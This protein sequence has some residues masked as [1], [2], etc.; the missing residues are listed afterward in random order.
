MIQ[1]PKGT[2]DILPDEVFK[3]QYIEE[4]VKKIFE[5]P[6]MK[7][8]RV[9]FL[10]IQNCFQEVLEKLLMLFKRKCI[11]LKIRAVEVLL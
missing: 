6:G 1:K 4:K 9:L 10:N 7:E 5:N 11:L 2:K 8:I 3:W